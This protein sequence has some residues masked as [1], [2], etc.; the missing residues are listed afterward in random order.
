V[1][2][3][4]A[5]T[6]FWRKIDLPGHDI[7]HLFRLD[8]GWCLSGTSLFLDRQP[9]HLHYKVYTDVAWRTRSAL[10]SGFLGKKAVELRI[11]H[12]DDSC[13][14][15]INDIFKDEVAGCI[16][17][18]LGFT[19]ST[20][21]IVIRRLGLKVGQ[22]AEAPAAYLQFPKL[23]FVKLPQTYIRIGRDRYQYD[24]P[25]VGYSGTL[26]VSTIGSVIE[27]P[28]LFEQLTSC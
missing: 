8:R 10:V 7:C 6:F 9:C 2:I 26:R 15:Q 14:W 24:A 13:R 11:R 1:S 5:A 17:I 27:Y 25:T 4:A 3:P 18:D 20:N 19:P 16:D 21:M 12:I 23:Q 28:G 22:W